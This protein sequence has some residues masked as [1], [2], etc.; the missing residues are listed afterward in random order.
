[1]GFEQLSNILNYT[2]TEDIQDISRLPII[3]SNDY[4]FE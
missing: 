4:E 1:M 3:S 2:P